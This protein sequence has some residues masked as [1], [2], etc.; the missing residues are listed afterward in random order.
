MNEQRYTVRYSGTTPSSGDYTRYKFTVSKPA[1]EEFFTFVRISGS[2]TGREQS[3]QLYWPRIAARAVEYHLQ[4][5]I[6]LENYRDGEILVTTYWQPEEPRQEYELFE[7]PIP[8]M[9]LPG[10]K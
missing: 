3:N 6:G 1:R 9:G 7:V 10:I 2:L 4:N 5:K 8:P